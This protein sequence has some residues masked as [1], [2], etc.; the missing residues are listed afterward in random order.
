MAAARKFCS[1]RAAALETSLAVLFGGATFM[2]QTIDLSKTFI[3]VSDG[4]DAETVRVTPT[5]WRSSGNRYDRL[6]G[7]FDFSSAKD[8]HSSMQEMHPE[9][10]EVLFVVAGAIDVVL[11]EGEVERSVAL[12]SGQAAI[13]P[14][15]VWH[16]LFMRQP[17][18]L[19][20]INSRKGMQG[21]PCRTS[22]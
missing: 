3:H 6:V 15:G 14:R 11:E 2:R 7:V 9:A 1:R 17:G 5:F 10:D 4:G 12:E 21:R 22:G 16:R 19:L 13:V 18:R 20:F 8:L